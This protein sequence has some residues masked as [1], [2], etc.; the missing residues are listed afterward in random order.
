MIWRQSKKSQ[1]MMIFCDFPPFEPKRWKITKNHNFLRFFKL[2]SNHH[3][4]S[5]NVFGVCLGTQ[6]SFGKHLKPFLIDFERKIEKSPTNQKFRKISKNRIFDQNSI[7]LK[8]WREG[9]NDDI[10]SKMA[11][12]DPQMYSGA[13]V[14]S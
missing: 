13:A 10:W 3:M 8:F 7:F 5:S 14:T 1:K 11:F 4:M 12:W 6:R 2:S 9:S